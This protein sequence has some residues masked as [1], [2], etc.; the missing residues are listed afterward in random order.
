[1]CNNL[2]CAAIERSEGKPPVLVLHGTVDIYCAGLLHELADTLLQ[3]QEDVVVSCERLAHLDTSAL[4]SLLALERGLQA[5]GRSMR[6]TGVSAEIGS[7]LQ[8]AGVKNAFHAQATA[9]CN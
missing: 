1:M 7:L 2:T 8:L 4:Q 3:E 5:R 6:L 9:Q